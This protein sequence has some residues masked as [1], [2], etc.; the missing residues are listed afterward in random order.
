MAGKH[1]G[2]ADFAP[3]TDHGDAFD[4]LSAEQKADEFDASTEDPRGY[5]ERNFGAQPGDQ[6]SRPLG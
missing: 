4:N 3:G 6:G 5:A 2:G 1:G